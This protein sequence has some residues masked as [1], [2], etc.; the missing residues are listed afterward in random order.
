MSSV[1]VRTM[2]RE[3]LAALISG[4]DAPWPLGQTYDEQVVLASLH[5]EGIAALAFEQLSRNHLA[6]PQQLRATMAAAAREASMH[7]L[8]FN[9]ETRRILRVFFEAGLP[10]LLLKGSALSYWLYATP[11]LRER[12]DI[13]LLFRTKEDADQ[14][15]M[16]LTNL[17][18][19]VR[20]KFLP[21]DSITFEITCVSQVGISAGNE[22]DVHWQLSSAPAFAFKFTFDELWADAQYFPT[23]AANAAGLGQ[24][25]AYLHGCMHRIQNMATGTQDKLKWL[26]DLHLLGQRFTRAEWELLVQTAIDRGLAGACL[27]GLSAAAQTFSTL[28]PET[29][30]SA[31]ASASSNEAMNVRRMHSWLYIQWM[32]FLAFPTLRLR[33]RWLLQRILPSW[34]YMSEYYGGTGWLR[35]LAKR[36]LGGLK[37]LVQ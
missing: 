8:R 19:A 17:D 4:S 31:L 14:A 29:V 18:Y 33:L 22:V 1:D 10:C 30:V 16:L 37:R 7:S 3:W 12:A 26:Y 2:L 5:A 13:D 20:E 9:V 24:V 32:S 34:N 36:V 25:H 35:L 28:A 27:D 23:V 21:G 6:C 11:A 15:I